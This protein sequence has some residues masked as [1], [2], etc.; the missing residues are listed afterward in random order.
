MKDELK[1]HLPDPD[2]EAGL[3]S[4]EKSPPTFDAQSLLEHPFHQQLMSCRK[5][6]TFLLSDGSADLALATG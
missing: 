3:R 5:K 4:W 6:T 1:T 2:Q